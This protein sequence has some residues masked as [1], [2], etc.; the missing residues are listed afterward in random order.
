MANFFGQQIN[1]WLLIL[2]ILIFLIALNYKRIFPSRCKQCSSLKYKLTA[3]SVCANKF[4]DNC[5]STLSV[6]TP[7]L[8]CGDMLC[9]DCK[10][11]HKYEGSPLS[12]AGGNVSPPDS[13]A[14]VLV[15]TN[16]T[17]VER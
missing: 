5:M 8:K 2:V 1:N 7:C 12:L 17:E 15:N 6:L 14:P 13:G 10:D 16:P 11:A 4:C 3:C 9:G